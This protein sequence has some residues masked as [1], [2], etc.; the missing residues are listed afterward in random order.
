MVAGFDAFVDAL[1]YPMFVVTATHD[2]RRAGCLVGFATQ[3]SI[4]PATYLVCISKKNHTFEVARRAPAVAVHALT[5][6][7]R[8]LAELFGEQTGDEMDKFA[9]CAWSPGP[10]GVPLLD[11]CRLRFAAT[12]DRRLDLGDHV[13]LLVTPVETPPAPAAVRQAHAD[14]LTFQAVRDMEPGHPA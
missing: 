6:A 1:D 4:D 10:H 12:V 9:R 11:E 8:A 2:G 13:G 3:V 5:R 14:L 7:H